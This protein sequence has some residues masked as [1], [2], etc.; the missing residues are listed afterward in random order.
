MNGFSISLL[1]LTGFETCA[2]FIEE[3]GPFETE[4]DQRK[5]GKSRKVSI[6][7]KT[8]NNM[9]FLVCLINPTIAFVTL[10]VVDLPT[11]TSNSAIILSVVGERAAGTWLRRLVAIDAILVL[12][13]GVLT[14][15]VGVTG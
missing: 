6:F 14:A 8:L 15:F 2:N 11:I 12:S 10:G 3:A 4:A 9:F 5:T 7:E 13:G 1:G